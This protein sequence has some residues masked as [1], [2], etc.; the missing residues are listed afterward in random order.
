MIAAWALLQQ[1]GERRVEPADLGFI[2]LFLDPDDPRSAK[3]QLHA[4][5]QHGGGWHSMPGFSIGDDMLLCYPG[6][7]PMHPIAVTKIHD[8]QVLVYQ[9]S[10]VVIMK[11]DHSFEVCRMD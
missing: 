8:E 11:P 2:P 3:E 6:D 10:W 4:N 7:P 1:E 5:Y 9:H